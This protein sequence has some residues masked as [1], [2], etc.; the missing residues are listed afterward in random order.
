ML[1]TRTFVAITCIAFSVVKAAPIFS[2]YVPEAGFLLTES[3]SEYYE[4]IVDQVMLD[5]S[6]DVLSFIPQSISHGDVQGNKR[7]YIV[8]LFLYKLIFFFLFFWVYSPSA[9]SEI[10]KPQS[11]L[12][13]CKSIS[14][15]K[16]SCVY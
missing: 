7:I 13:A 5:V 1:F 9:C 10:V 11:Q 14:I 3:L 16:S 4:N 6:E 8:Y 2:T 12:Y 15:C